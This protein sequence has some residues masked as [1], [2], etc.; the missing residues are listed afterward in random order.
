MPHT[1]GSVDIDERFSRYVGGTLGQ[2]GARELN[3]GLSRFK[4]QFAAVPSIR[5]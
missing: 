2:I 4:S 5:R 1:P 3:L